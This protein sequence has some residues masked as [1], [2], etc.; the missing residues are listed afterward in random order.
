MGSAVLH[1]IEWA[2][3]LDSASLKCGLNG[4]FL[5]LRYPSKPLVFQGETR[6]HPILCIIHFI[7]V[8]GNVRNMVQG[9]YVCGFLEII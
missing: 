2:H 6:T 7:Q 9:C 4:R 5:K 8:Q 1:G 3:A